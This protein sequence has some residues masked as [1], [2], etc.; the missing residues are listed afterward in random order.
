MVWF[1]FQIYFFKRKW[2]LFYLDLFSDQEN[3]AIINAA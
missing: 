3:Y 1:C 2:K